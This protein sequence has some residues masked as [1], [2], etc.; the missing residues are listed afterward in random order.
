M[1]KHNRIILEKIIDEAGFVLGLVNNLSEP[2][3]VASEVI[4][5]AI[6]MTLINIGELVKNLNDDLRQNNSHIP[7]KQ[8]AGFRDV[9]S[10]GYLTLRF[11]EVWVYA[12]R[13]VPLLKA[14]MEEILANEEETDRS[15]PTA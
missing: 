12:S 5:R 11:P 7:W 14:Q 4:K 15:S 3:F 8:I 13:D 9:A 10:H 6:C 2:E 1:N